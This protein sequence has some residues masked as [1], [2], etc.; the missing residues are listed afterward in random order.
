VKLLLK[1]VA[2]MNY[3][4]IVCLKRLQLPGMI[5]KLF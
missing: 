3:T 5:F 2:R 1:I 4:R